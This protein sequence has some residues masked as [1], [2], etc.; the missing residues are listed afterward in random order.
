VP[1]LALARL[2]RLAAGVVVAII[3]L[4]IIFVVLDASGTNGIVSTVR[5]WAGTLT[6]PFHGV[7]HVSSHKGT[8]ALNYGLAIVVYL[9][10]AAIVEGL[11][12]GSTFNGRRRP[13]PY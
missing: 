6:S 5:E 10:L 13:L 12:A 8:V 7:F 9:A 4:A 11:L 2:V 1:D 3:A